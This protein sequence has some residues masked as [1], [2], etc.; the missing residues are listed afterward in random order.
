M[1]GSTVWAAAR[2]EA[3]TAEMLGPIAARRP[4]ERQGRNALGRLAAACGAGAVD[5]A[6]ATAVAAGRA[7]DRPRSR[8]AERRLAV[9][10]ADSPRGRRDRRADDASFGGSDRAPTGSRS[11]TRANWLRSTR[12]RRCRP[13][14]VATRSRSAR[15]NPIGWRKT[16]RDSFSCAPMIIDGSVRLEQPNGH[17]WVPQAGGGVSRSHRGDHARQADAGRRVHPHD[18]PSVLG[19]RQGGRL[20]RDCADRH[21]WRMHPIG[22]D[23]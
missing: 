1:A 8:G 9:S 6:S 21:G 19:G 5:V 12:R 22:F 10:G 15:P 17:Q 14:S 7:F 23:E 16:S 2:C 3:R 18:G 4:A 11:C 20:T 13:R